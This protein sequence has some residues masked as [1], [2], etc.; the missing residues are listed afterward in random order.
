[1]ENQ[2]QNSV[3]DNIRYYAKQT[4]KWVKFLAILGFIFVGLM[5]V[6]SLILLFAGGSLMS[7]NPYGSLLPGGGATVIGIVYLVVTALYFYPIYTLWKY[8]VE[9]NIAA[10]QDDQSALE[11]SFRWIRSHFRF[12]GIIAVI[13]ISLYALVLIFALF[14]NVMR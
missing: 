12:V 8:G 9:L 6:A 11:E 13:F 3:S 1:M 14:A 10:D 5:I 7:M 4:S 2:L